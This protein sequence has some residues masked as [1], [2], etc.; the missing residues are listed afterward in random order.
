VRFDLSTGEGGE[1]ASRHRGGSVG[2]GGW[3]GARL[4]GTQRRDAQASKG[5]KTGVA[6]A[7]ESRAGQTGRKR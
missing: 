3:E 6:R 1:R 4:E 7:Q 5:D 2:I